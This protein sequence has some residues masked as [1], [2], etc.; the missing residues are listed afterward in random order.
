RSVSFA[1]RNFAQSLR[2]PTIFHFVPTLPL[3]SR[4]YDEIWK[5]NGRDRS[6]YFKN[7]IYLAYTREAYG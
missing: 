5:E 7:A 1:Q 4:D 3:R 2:F 6:I